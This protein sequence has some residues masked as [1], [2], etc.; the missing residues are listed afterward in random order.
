M[1]PTTAKIPTQVQPSTLNRWNPALKSPQ[2]QLTAYWEK[3]ENGKLYCRW[4][5][6]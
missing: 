6:S 1:I 5:K 4:V 3:D 2:P